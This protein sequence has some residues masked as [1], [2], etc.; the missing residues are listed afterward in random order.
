MLLE[1]LWILRNGPEFSMTLWDSHGFSGIL[2][3]VVRSSFD[4]Q[5]LVSRLRRA[6]LGFQNAVVYWRCFATRRDSFPT[7]K[8]T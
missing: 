6:F 1:F 8:W 4:I 7:K 2:F 3:C 5:G